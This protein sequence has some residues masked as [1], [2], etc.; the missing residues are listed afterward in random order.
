MLV[1]YFF[2]LGACLG[3][4]L[5]CLF[6]RMY[7]ANKIPDMS[8]RSHCTSCGRQLV[9][10]D[11]IPIVSYL[12]YRGKCRTC[13]ATIPITAFLAEILAGTAWAY[14]CYLNISS[15][16]SQAFILSLLCIILSIESVSDM[17]RGESTWFGL[18]VMLV[19]AVISRV[20][21][22]HLGWAVCVVPIFIIM[23]T[24]IGPYMGG[25]D[26]AAYIAVASIT[27]YFTF[28]LVMLI[29]ALLGILVIIGHK[30]RRHSAA[31]VRMLP[32]ITVAVIAVTV[33]EPLWRGVFL[34]AF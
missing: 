26:I 10:Y 34:N 2:A 31:G 11:L 1:A 7:Q 16:D 15:N 22:G 28:T 33:A 21:K 3:S 17:E 13:K 4:F 27:D 19:L 6:S 18:G 5:D 29:S 32:C 14:A 24:I 12:A 9:W 20:L 25:A 8:G 23:C 30:L